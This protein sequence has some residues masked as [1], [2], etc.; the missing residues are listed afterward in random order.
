MK[1]ALTFAASSAASR[2]EPPTL[3]QKLSRH[4]SQSLF[5]KNSKY[6]AGDAHIDPALPLQD[7]ERVRGLVIERDVRA[8][9]L[10]ELDLLVGPRGRDDFAPVELGELDDEGADGAASCGDECGF[11]L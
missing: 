10:H 9:A 1:R 11:A 7:L 4:A 2:V 6:T 8:D 5:T 3:S